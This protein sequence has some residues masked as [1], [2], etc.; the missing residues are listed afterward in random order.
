MVGLNLKGAPVVSKAAQDRAQHAFDILAE[1]QEMVTRMGLPEYPRPKAAPVPLSDL[2]ISA[3][4]NQEVAA[5]MANYIAYAQYVGAKVA[6]VEAAY[7]ISAANLKQIA[8]TQKVSLFNDATPKTEI[9]ARI[10]VSPEYQKH[11]YEHLKLYATKS[12]LSAYYKSYSRQAQALSRIVELRK[13]EYEQ[14][15]RQNAVNS[16]RVPGRGGLPGTLRR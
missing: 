2:D 8:A 5:Q 6:E 3:L 16:H 13:L 14:E 7:K 12:I 15:A 11:E 4:T 10:T 9:E 1:I